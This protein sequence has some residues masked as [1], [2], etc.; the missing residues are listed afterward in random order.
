[1][2]VLHVVHQFAPETRGGTE[3][4]VQDVARLQRARGLDAQVLTGSL[5]AWPEAGCEE[6]AVEGIP[7][8]RVHRNDLYFDHHVKAWHPG[9]SSLFGELLARRRPRLVHVHHWIRL[10]CDLVE[11]AHAHGIPAVVTLHDFYTSCPRAFRARR[12]DPACL[13]PVGAESCRDCVPRYGHEPQAEL[14]EGI[15]LFA[16]GFR[17][18]LALARS[19][20]VAVGSTADLLSRTTG[21]PRDRY[22]VLP[23]GYRPRFP[24]RPHLPPPAPG[25]AMR[26][27]FWGGVGR[28]KGVATLVAAIGR[29]VAAGRRAELHVLGGFESPQFEHELRAVAAGLP[30]AF[31]GPF[32]PDRIVALSPHC[33]VFPS[34]CLETFGIVLDECFELGLPCIVSDLGALPERA[35]AAALVVRAGDVDDLALALQRLCDDPGEWHRLQARIAAAPPRLEDHVDRLAAIYAAACSDAVPAPAT[36]TVPLQRR[37]RFLLM[38]RD[39]AQSRVLPPGGPA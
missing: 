18:E 36:A 29:L 1:M 25:E 12:D 37:L 3:S 31:H 15:E 2:D 11:I 6:L 38:Q 17:G 28:H 5:A 13:R 16:A 8:H 14:D 10:S 33:G 20:L 30:V 27:A 9:V 35:G 34:T 39:S 19:V 24:G 23:L 22:T 7:V 21:L 4:Y 26:F 32:T